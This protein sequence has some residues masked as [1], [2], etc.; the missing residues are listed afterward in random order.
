M[1]EII[2][3]VKVLI[4][5]SAHQIMPMSVQEQLVAKEIVMDPHQA[6]MKADFWKTL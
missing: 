3:K 5:K 6:E 4:P 1:P 2:L